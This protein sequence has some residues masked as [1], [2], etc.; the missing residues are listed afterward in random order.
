MLCALLYRVYADTVHRFLSCLLVAVTATAWMVVSGLHD[1]LHVLVL[2]E[3]V[4]IGIL[5]TN[6]WRS[7]ALRPM[8]YAL[9]VSLP[10][11]LLLVL[12]PVERVHTSWWPSRMILTA[13]L[14]WLYQWV[15][16][17]W[18]PLR[19][20]PLIWA[21]V[22]TLLLGAVSTPGVLAGIGLL[23]L[24]Y[25]RPDRLLL[26]LGALFFPAF[27][28]IY[29]YNLDTPLVAKSWILAASGAVLL[30]AR[31]GLSRGTWAREGGR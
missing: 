29:Y 12:A 14:L 22:A 28:G 1:G 23:V 3:M 25:G 21:V 9:A 17:G 18:A 7:A 31:W 6:L 11:T 19:K 5:F 24:G 30:L 8:A 13:G 26:G 16:G 27:I 20:P 2:C 10:L 4:G 15:A